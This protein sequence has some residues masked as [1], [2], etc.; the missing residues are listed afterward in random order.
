M[1]EAQ[2]NGRR[3]LGGRARVSGPALTVADRG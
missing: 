2:G 1:A 3:V